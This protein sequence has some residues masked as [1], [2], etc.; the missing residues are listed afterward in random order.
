MKRKFLSAL[1]AFSLAFTA[2]FSSINVFAAE[3]DI[4]AF[5]VN[6]TTYN[7]RDTTDL[8]TS[9][10]I[11]SAGDEVLTLTWPAVDKNGTIIK[12]NPLRS[13]S[14]YGNP[15][16]SW[17]SV[18]QGMVIAYS[19]WDIKG[20]SQ[21]P[22]KTSTGDE[23]ILMGL[24]STTTD[25]PVSIV[26]AHD[27]NIQLGTAYLSDEVVSAS[28]FATA[29]V[30]E[31]SKDGVEFTQ[32][33]VVSSIDHGKKLVRINDDGTTTN[34]RGTTYFLRDQFVEEM[35]S[36]L[37]PDTE[38][39]I[40]V[41]ATNAN[42]TSVTYRSFEQ[43]VIT[44]EAAEK[45]P[46]FATVEG[47]GT[48]SQG[49]RGGDVYVV[50]NLTDSVSDPQPGSLRYGLLRKDRADGNT[51]APRTIVFAVGGTINVDETASKSARRFNITDNTTILGQTAPGEG[52]TIAGASIKFTGENIIVR[53]VDFRL[54]G[55]Y[56]LDAATA[57]GRYIV[58]DH[59]SFSWGV[60]EVF[61]AKEIL[62]SSIQYN[63]M[64]SGLAVPDK[65]GINNS[66]AEIASGESEAKHGMGSILNGYEV[67]YTHNLWAHN[68]TRNPRFEGG[69][70]YNG[71][72]Y[73]NKIDY[74]NNV[75]YNWG[76]N[77]TYGGERGNGQMNFVGNY[78]KPG[79]ETL[80][81]VKYQ[82]VDCDA[83]GSYKSSYYVDGNI[84]TSDENVTAN[85]ELGF[86]DSQNA[87]LLSEPVEL[88]VPYTASS[89]DEAYNKVL[90]TVGS[91]LHRDAQDARLIYEVENGLGAF[92]NDQAEAGGWSTAVYESEL[93]D[94][95]S[96]GLPDDYETQNGLNPNDASDSAA[97]IT[98]ENS[99]YYGYSNIEVYA[100]NL[101]GDWDNMVTAE[102]APDVQISQILDANGNNIL[103][104][105]GN[106]TLTVGQTY[107]IVSSKAVADTDIY[108]NDKVVTDNNL[109][110]TPDEIGVYNLSCL[111]T[112]NGYSSFSV[113]VPVTVV[114]GSSNLEG[115]TS[116]DIGTVGA[117]GADNYDASTGTLYS[118]GA[119][120]I[121]TTNTSGSQG[122][123]AFHY[124]YKQVTGDFEFTAKMDNLAKIDYAQKSGIMLRG[125]LD[126]SSEFYMA[127]LTY[128][129]GE[130]YAGSTDVSGESVKAKNIRA[131][132]RLSNDQTVGSSKF[133][134]IPITRVDTEKNYG[135]GR[136]TRIG[137]TITISA[138][139]DGTQWYTLAE[140]TST[141]LPDT[142][143]IGFATEAAQDTSEK[144]RY[145]VTAF[146]EITLNET[147]ATLLLGDTNCDGI[148]T[149]NDAAMILQYSLD[150]TS[151]DISEQ[152]LKNAMVLTENI[153][154]ANTAANILQKA[155]DA[156]FLFPVER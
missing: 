149:A 124:N 57:T 91:S 100:G 102:E 59:C 135:Y 85:N 19:G 18:T 87:V 21:N 5:A 152:G 141:T 81:K 4:E 83:S 58:I 42:D 65:N 144:V 155:L 95:D 109:S 104:E 69:F 107:T 103:T 112:E 30:V 90:S 136:I 47:G 106:T 118:Q 23:Q 79:P 143:Y 54:G 61:S 70:E 1:L 150:A 88:L 14:E 82:F 20:V 63:I 46:A 93:T 3:G 127:A 121:G 13:T 44:P 66:D 41:R 123:D 140:Y 125:T 15:M 28:G 27:S 96:D 17:T 73:E 129:K 137:D 74:A 32:D 111:S 126:P 9:F 72:R 8:E 16:G 99:I 6:D 43:K 134:G 48:Y 36:P 77:S 114:S 115:F 49:G 51:T 146:S 154:T 117:A 56:D 68:G 133:L 113:A 147:P 35:T 80:E 60:D 37:E 75:V 151:V 31:Y 11:N 39:T 26:D 145:N 24:T 148:I 76:H 53:Y 139:L 98:D 101:V 94:S 71:V 12:T 29:Y 45:T 131:M 110:F 132:S 86:S 67:S 52:I 120:R 22:T 2:A 78:Y 122:P 105:N 40:R 119:G 92:I 108:L 84:M 138:S 7:F 153:Y 142:C 156:S 55:G 33:H 25:Y 89:A 116:V 34:D 64:S 62:N 97:L 128:L 10:E 130:D 38:Y 50:T